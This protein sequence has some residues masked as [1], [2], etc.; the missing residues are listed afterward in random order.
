MSNKPN[1]FIYLILLSFLLV[2]NFCAYSET[3]KG[4]EVY[5]EVI[6]F[7]DSSEVEEN[8]YTFSPIH[9]YL[10]SVFNHYGLRLK[11]LDVNAP[12]PAWL[13]NKKDFL[14]YAG[15]VSWFTDNTMREAQSYMA[16]L[17]SAKAS[18]L[19]LLLMGEPGFHFETPQKIRSKEILIDFWNKLG[20]KYNGAY[21]SNPLL[22]QMEILSKKESDVQFERDFDGELPGFWGLSVQDKQLMP[23][24]KTTTKEVKN[25]EFHPLVVGE[26]LAII[27]RGFEIFTNTLDY[28]VQWRVN[29][30]AV[31]KKLFISTSWPIPDVTTLCGRRAAFAHIDGDGFINVSLIDKK[32]YSGEIIANQIIKK[33]EFPTTVSVVTAEVD[34]RYLGNKET[35]SI[36]KELFGLPYVEA[37]SHTFR[38]PLSWEKNPNNREKDI[39]LNDKDILTHTGPIVAYLKEKGPINYKDEISHTFDF[40]NTNLLENKKSNVLLWTGSCRP[41][42]EALD[43]VDRE[44]ILHMNG[45]DGRYDNS[46]PSY[47]GLSSLY[48]K[49]GGSLQV[50]SAFANENIYTN[51][52]AGPY[53]GFRNVI[54]SFENTE[55][56]FRVKPINIYYHFYS[57]ERVSSLKA[58]D[59]IY[60]Y[61]FKQE[62][63]PIFASDYI[64]MVRGWESVRIHRVNKLEFK[65]EDYGSSRTLRLDLD[66]GEVLYP[67]YGGSRNVVGHRREGNSLYITLSKGKE[68][69]LKLS[70]KEPK[71]KYIQSCNGFINEFSAQKLDAESRDF[72]KATIKAENKQF[73]IKS[74][75]RVFSESWRTDGSL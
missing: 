65:I 58:L 5:R 48:R 36:M 61:L 14:K 8:E 25:V 3:A 62:V 42:K 43:L 31:I 6:A 45:G 66:K 70:Y 71:S 22:M 34:P 55:K 57:G 73:E 15:A 47:A 46:Y 54:E 56:P 28:K 53:S 49:I 26:K 2:W 44:G 41:P 24:L 13:N 69:Y 51:L 1:S 23:W 32:S 50:Y 21:Y 39:Y 52:W 10:E 59:E 33:Y 17:E 11:Y 75:R 19:P 63:T 72:F 7:W 67:D 12:L 35:L 9:F 68:A 37:A 20:M 74:E 40:I 18:G 60:S 4:R 64:K 29:P 16:F 30:F 27:Q 38:H